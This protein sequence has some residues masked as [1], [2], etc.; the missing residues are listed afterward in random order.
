[1]IIEFYIR[2]FVD[3]YRNIID[4]YS[5]EKLIIY[6]K[7]RLY[8]YI[9]IHTYIHVHIIHVHTRAHLFTFGIHLVMYAAVCV[10][11]VPRKKKRKK[12]YQ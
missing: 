9:Y 12:N 3:M 5:I 2:F 4:I 1:M 8:I 7:R 11:R 10:K 6:L